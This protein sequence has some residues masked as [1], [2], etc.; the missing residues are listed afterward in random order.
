[1]FYCDAQ[2]QLPK[3]DPGTDNAVC[4]T[5]LTNVSF[6]GTTIALGFG[7]TLLLY[8]TC[9]GFS[10]TAENAKADTEIRILHKSSFR[11]PIKSSWDE[12]DENSVNIHL[13]HSEKILNQLETEKTIQEVLYILIGEEKTTT[14]RVNTNSNAFGAQDFYITNYHPQQEESSFIHFFFFR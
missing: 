7:F 3:Y 1:M 11:E 2:N 12:R 5:Q 8:Y 9:S 14:N 10:K 4:G 13:R 6:Y